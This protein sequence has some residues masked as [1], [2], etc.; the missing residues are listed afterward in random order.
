MSHS[1]V[2]SLLLTSKLGT[3]M[4]DTFVVISNL[5]STNLQFLVCFVLFLELFFDDE[6]PRNY[7]DGCVSSGVPLVA[8]LGNS[9]TLIALYAKTS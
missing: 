7:L 1:I 5:V 2:V 8:I 9:Y 3:V 6:L 4:A